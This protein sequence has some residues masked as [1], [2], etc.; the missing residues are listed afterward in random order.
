MKVLDNEGNIKKGK[1]GVEYA[2]NLVYRE[3]PKIVKLNDG[4]IA[5]YFMAYTE[6]EFN[7]KHKGFDRDMMKVVYDSSYNRESINI[8][9]T[10]D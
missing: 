4:K 6:D 1:H 5:I 8:L 7:N 10:L 3:T 9:Y 2:S